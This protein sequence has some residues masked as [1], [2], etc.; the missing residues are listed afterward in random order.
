MI[1]KEINNIEKMFASPS[2]LIHGYN[3]TPGTNK[4]ILL[5]IIYLMISF[6][7]SL[8]KA[9]LFLAWRRVDLDGYIY[10]KS[11]K[12]CQF[13]FQFEQNLINKNGFKL[14]NTAFS[15]RI[16]AT[17]E[18]ILV[19][20]LINSRSYDLMKYWG[21]EFD[22]DPE[23]W[24]Q[25][26]V[27]TDQSLSQFLKQIC[28]D[29]G[30][31]KAEGSQRSA[32]EEEIEEI[33]EISGGLKTREVS[34]K[35]VTWSVNLCQV[36]GSIDDF[37]TRDASGVERKANL[38]NLGKN[39]ENGMRKK[40]IKNGPKNK[41]EDFGD[42]FE[43]DYQGLNDKKV[44]WAKKS[45]ENHLE[46]NPKFENEN[47]KSR[48][49]KRSTPIRAMTRNILKRP[50]SPEDRIARNLEKLNKKI[51]AEIFSNAAVSGAI[52]QSQEDGEPHRVPSRLRGVAD[53]SKT[54]I[55]KEE[56]SAK[57]E[58]LRNLRSSLNLSKRP[59]MH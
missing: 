22:E 36:I 5:S 4:S 29:G 39:L 7:W 19:N 59:K 9:K 44:A 41:D 48:F 11:P 45:V 51:S 46:K 32:G 34:K 43:V 40:I 42:D 23:V 6:K 33:S 31:E 47:E 18:D 2:V 14:S 10:L 16:G 20:T 28:S 26:V 12:I 21:G 37:E 49:I 50:S 8:Q 25:D 17:D 1:V 15:R 57:Y 38:L 24:P 27:E 58:R 54:P 3:S 13:L 30:D 52:N 55:K 35:F 53:R 56:S